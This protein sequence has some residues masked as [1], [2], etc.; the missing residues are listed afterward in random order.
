VNANGSPSE[1][2][3]RR[4][5]RYILLEAIDRG[6][7]AEVYRAVT[8]GPGGFQRQF[9]IKRIRQE[10]AT[11][12]EFVEMFINEARISALLEHPN[13]VQVYDFGQVEGD[14]FLAMEYLR[15]RNLLAL[16]RRLRSHGIE[17]PVDLAAYVA[18][19]TAR[20][21]YH[22]HTLTNQGK[23]LGIVHRD[24]SPSNIM[25]LRTGGVK[26]LDFGIARA[27]MK[28]RSVTPIG[29]LVKGKLSYLSPEQVRGQGVD[30]RSDIFSLGVVLWECLTGL[31]LFYDPNDL[32]TMRNVLHRPI[33]PPSAVRPGVP[34][35]LDEITMRALGRDLDARYPDAAAFAAELEDYLRECRFS[36]ESA[37]RLLDELFAGEDSARELPLPGEN[38]L[39]LRAATATT[40][41]T[42][43]TDSVPPPAAPDDADDTIND[44]ATVSSVHRMA[45][46]AGRHRR[47]RI[48]QV[49]AAGM[50]AAGALSVA[51]LFAPGVRSGRAPVARPAQIQAS[52]A[53]WADAGAGPESVGGPVVTQ[54]M[55]PIPSQAGIEIEPAVPPDEDALVFEETAPPAVA[56]SRSRREESGARASRERERERARA[57]SAADPARARRA[58]GRGVEA[59]RTGEYMLAVQELEGALLAAPSSPEVLKALAEAEF[60]LARY[61]RALA[62]ARRAVSLAPKDAPT[63][64]L[65]GDAYFKLRRFKEA[66]EAYAAAVALAP[67]DASIRARQKRAGEKM[68]VIPPETSPTPSE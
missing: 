30:N 49:S 28:L 11:S 5:G 2:T 15:G 59:M 62:H 33:P 13:I 50:V 55:D 36:P 53:H 67:D 40:R 12:K 42:A 7:M 24:V 3:G 20:G 6:G 19:E 48:I 4:F 52:A 1:P 35:A 17:M 64:A 34:A 14:Y 43:P 56:G 39:R 58:L 21:L 63:R 66:S 27:T 16:G 47:R 61:P 57:S 18:R 65:L 51:V 37:V 32:E 31:R 8:Q 46:L 38:S 44:Y 23:P 26:L 29:G 25:L 45:E 9:V 60:E 68:G 10:K 41:G 22:A 54:L